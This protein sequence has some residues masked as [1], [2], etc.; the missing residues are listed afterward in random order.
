MSSVPYVRVLEAP[1]AEPITLTQAKLWCKV[2]QTAED[3]LLELLIQAVRERAE[4]ITGRAFVQRR[5]ELRLDKFPADPVI[6][7]PFAPLISV[8]YVKYIDAAGTLQTLEGSPTN[9]IEDAGSEPGRIQPLHG[10]SWPNTQDVIAAVRIG[11][12]CGYAPAAG[13]PTDYASNIPA[14]AKQW[15]QARLASF[16]ENREHIVVGKVVN[17]PPRDFVDG[18]LD[19]LIVHKRFA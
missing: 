16:Y 13:S 14:R 7:L 1:A 9:W 4:E 17:Q 12:Q 3:A 6:E 5:M 19:G 15:M 11:F 18:L 8:E 2:D 10:T